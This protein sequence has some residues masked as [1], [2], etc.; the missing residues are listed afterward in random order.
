MGHQDKCPSELL[1]PLYRPNISL[2][3]RALSPMYLSTIA[4]ATTFMKLHCMFEAMALK[5]EKFVITNLL[6][7]LLSLQYI[8]VDPQ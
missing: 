7:S 4:D 6:H 2:M 5:K 8:D 3:T 1:R